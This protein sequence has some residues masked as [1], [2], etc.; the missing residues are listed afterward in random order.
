MNLLYGVVLHTVNFNTVIPPVDPMN[1]TG[2]K[3]KIKKT[4]LYKNESKRCYKIAKLF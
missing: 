4:S 2:K 1:S 3:K